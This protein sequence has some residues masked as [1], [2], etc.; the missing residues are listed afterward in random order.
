MMLKKLQLL[1]LHSYM[2]RAADVV[3]MLQLVGCGSGDELGGGD[4]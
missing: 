4:K 1:M 2:R 3:L